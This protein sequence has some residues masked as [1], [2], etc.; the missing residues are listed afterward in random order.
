VVSDHLEGFY[1]TIFRI[2]LVL[3]FLSISAYT[4]IVILEDG[5]NLFPYFFDDMAEL[6]WP[7]QFNLDF[8]MM[9]SLS[10]IWTSW[11]NHFSGSGLVLGVCAFFLGAP[12]LCVYLMF[13]SFQCNGD[14]VQVLVGPQ[15]A[16]PEATG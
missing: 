14:M 10:A 15:R 6:S 9:L 13:L 7:G 3:V 16:K 12:F 2:W 5:L 11:R 8:M 1:M 4:G